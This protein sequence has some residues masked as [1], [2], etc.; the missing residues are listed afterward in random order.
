M[1]TVF[2]SATS[3]DLKSYRA[4]VAEWARSRGYEPIVQDE[5]PV[6]SDY[7]T[8]LQMLRER[9]DPCDAV[10]HLAGLF[11]GFGPINRPAGEARRSYTQLEYELAKVHRRQVFRFIA[12]PDYE[13]DN[14]I[15]QSEEE[16]ELQHHHRR[17]LMYGNEAWSATSRTTG[18]ELYYEFSN[19]AELRRLLDSIQ[20]KATLAK[21]QNLPVVGSLFKGRD[22]FIAQLR[23]VLVSKPTHPAAVTA[24]QAIHGLGGVGKTRVA[25]EY[26][27][28][29][30]HEYTALLCVRADSPSILEQHLAN[31][32]G[33]LVLNLPER[34][35]REQEVQVAAALRWLRE[36]SGWFLIIDNVDNR[37]AAQAVNAL[38]QQLETG[39]VIVTSRLSHW[40][41][42]VE[43]L[44]LDVLSET[45][46]RELLLERTQGKRKPLATDDTD[47]DALATDLGR[48]PLALEQGRGVHCPASRQHSGVPDPMETAGSQG[49]DVA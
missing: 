24:K 31:L 8:I 48:L 34:E 1:P 33:A 43:E 22:E 4:V 36:H 32:C 5:F 14:P 21:P 38:L 45:A 12:R 10:I 46:A 2:V 28:R 6:Q 15:Q 7:G 17:R 41:G 19:P 35:A 47:A 18:N 11:Y 37:E 29:Y 23:S 30:S 27:R 42:A 44:A 16:A 39:H 26:A 49:P 9:L 20:I 25:V 40:G 13:P 3:R